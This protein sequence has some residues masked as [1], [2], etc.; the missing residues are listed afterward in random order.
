MAVTR[1]FRLPGGELQRAVEERLLSGVASLA[2]LLAIVWLLERRTLRETGLFALP[3][4]GRRLAAG[5]ALGALPVLGHAAL[6]AAAGLYHFS[7]PGGASLVEAIG[8]GAVLMVVAVDEEIRFRGLVFRTLDEGA[9]S[10]VAMVASGLFFG[11]LHAG[12]RGATPLGVAVVAAGG[13]MLAACYL[14]HRSLWIPIG[15]HFAWN[16]TMGLLLGLP[17]S[18]AR[19]PALLH[20]DAA[21]PELWTGGSFGPEASLPVAAFV[22]AAAAL[23]V[24]RTAAQGK[25]TR[26]RWRRGAGASPRAGSAAPGGGA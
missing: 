1:A 3:A 4:L 13:V 23:I 25:L 16:A 19:I 8:L 26:A 6:L 18:G 21:G 5:L 12:N 11:L 10:W 20:A 15:F 7:W 22:T 9:G 14:L 17:I 2:A 24:W